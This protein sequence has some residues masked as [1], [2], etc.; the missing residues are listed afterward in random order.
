MS[1][2][3]KWIVKAEITYDVT[4]TVSARDEDDA[5][6]TVLELLEDEMLDLSKAKIKA[7]VYSTKKEPQ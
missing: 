2:I 6:F 3:K 4:V 5:T 7:E 1:T